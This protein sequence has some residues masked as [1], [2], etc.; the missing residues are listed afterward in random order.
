MVN[1]NGKLTENIPL[2]SIDN[3]GLAYG[4]AVF[5]TIKV[6]NS[7]IYFWEDHYFRLMA[8][9]RIMRM[10]IP[11]EFTM[12]FLETEILK[13]VD[14]NNLND[15]PTR[16]KFLVFRDS[17]GFYIPKSNA[18]AF[19]ISVKEIDTAQYHLNTQPYQVDIFKDYPITPGLLS[20]LKTN[21]RAINVVGGIYAKE[22]DLD[23]CILLNTNKQVVETLNGNIFMAQG[24]T[25]KTPP[26]L[27]GCIKGI[28][29][30]QLIDIIKASEEFTLEESSI[31]P[32]ELQRADE[33]FI[34]NVI[35]G[36]Q[37]ISAYRKKQYQ[38]VIA[39]RLI[40]EINKKLGG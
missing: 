32:F 2:F 19:V 20:T 35:A 25:I 38:S 13:T 28:F 21:N 40:Q 4:D 37:P 17:D 10:E 36:I 23:N 8:S 1:Y 18:I 31:S 16:I 9:M 34:T 11:M 30:K 39:E 29:R 3:R 22:N 12:E 14:A 26:I 15:K 7:K 5:E 27:D 33:L 6:A 24:N